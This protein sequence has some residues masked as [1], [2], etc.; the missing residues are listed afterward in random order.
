[1]A[2]LRGHPDFFERNPG[3][4]TNLSLTHAAGGA[5]SLIEHQVKVLRRDLE[6]ERGRLAQLIARARD[7]ETF[8]ARLHALVL[9]L[10]G[11][12]D[13]EQVRAALH[14]ALM[15]E[16]SAQA[17]T[18]K[19]F[20]LDPAEPNRDPVA[21]AFREFLGLEHALCGPLDAVKNRILFGDLGAQVQC[22]ALVP[23]RGVGCCGVLAIGA[24]D[25][26]RFK[27][28]MGTDLLDRLGEILS[29]KLR[30]LPIPARPTEPTAHGPDVKPAGKPPQAAQV[31]KRAPRK[32]KPQPAEEGADE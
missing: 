30:V 15:R 9:Q 11:A 26:D 12:T 19:L 13:L 3:V 20:A 4:L 6:T 27:P 28:D 5:T 10:V 1:A 23:I 2:Y 16:F 24:N 14:A 17:V 21:D 22:A 32:R 31:P 18:L 8:S 29:H 7:Y 25:P